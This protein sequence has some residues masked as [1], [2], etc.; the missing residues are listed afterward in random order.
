VPN[1]KASAQFVRLQWRAV[2]QGHRS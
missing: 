2:S 1:S